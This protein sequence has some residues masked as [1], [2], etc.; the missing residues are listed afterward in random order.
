MRQTST[1]SLIYFISHDSYLKL[2]VSILF[3]YSRGNAFE[4]Y[5]LMREQ[6]K[7]IFGETTGVLME[8]N[9][10]W[11]DIRSKTQQDLMRPKSA[12]FYLEEIQKVSDEFMDFIR[13]QRSP[14]R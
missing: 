12:H 2:I 6:R 8:N 4:S 7:D 3:S 1:Y 10:K 14:D 5:K 11:H 9:E 13:S